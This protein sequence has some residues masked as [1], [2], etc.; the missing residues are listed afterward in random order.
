MMPDISCWLTPGLHH[1]WMSPAW[2][3]V[4]YIWNPFSQ[5]LMWIRS[6]GELA[7]T[8][9]FIPS[10]EFVSVV[11]LG[12]KMCISKKVSSYADTNGLEI[13]ASYWIK[14]TNVHPVFLVQCHILYRVWEKKKVSF[15]KFNFINEFIDLQEY[16]KIQQKSQNILKK[17]YIFFS[18]LETGGSKIT[19]ATRVGFFEVSLPGL[20]MATFRCLHMVFPICTSLMSFSYSSCRPSAILKLGPILLASF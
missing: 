8:D 1:S 17:R 10:P 16:N 9:C 3:L 15:G 5:I 2:S 14:P 13:Y 20:Q 18:D 6:P 4:Q 11:P 12:S 19:G 7:E